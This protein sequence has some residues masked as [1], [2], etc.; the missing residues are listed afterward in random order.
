MAIL[1]KLSLAVAFPACLPLNAGHNLPIREVANKQSSLV[2]GVSM[3]RLVEVALW[4]GISAALLTPVTGLAGLL[5]ESTR[6][7]TLPMVC[8]GV[9]LGAIS[10]VIGNFL[11]EEFQT[12]F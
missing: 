11:A 9:G 7:W 10:L 4:L 3:R 6:W 5:V 2:V 12:E 1:G 8:L